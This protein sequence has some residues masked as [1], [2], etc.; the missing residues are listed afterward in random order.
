MRRTFVSYNVI[1]HIGQVPIEFF[2][3][4]GGEASIFIPTI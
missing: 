4:V 3:A 1:I 2:L